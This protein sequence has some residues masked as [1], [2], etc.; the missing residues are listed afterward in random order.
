MGDLASRLI[1]DYH[2]VTSRAGI[3]ARAAVAVGYEVVL[4]RIFAGGLFAMW[5]ERFGS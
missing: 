2:A 5:K 1:L 3:A 4:R